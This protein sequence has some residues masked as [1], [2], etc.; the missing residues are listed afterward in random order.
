MFYSFHGSDSGK[1]NIYLRRDIPALRGLRTLNENHHGKVPAY[2]S[3]YMLLYEEYPVS[4]LEN[5]YKNGSH[6]TVI[7]CTNN[8][9]FNLFIRIHVIKMN[10]WVL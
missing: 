2:S 8:H 10:I 6:L 7:H 1:G 4:V 5:C 9:A 3:V